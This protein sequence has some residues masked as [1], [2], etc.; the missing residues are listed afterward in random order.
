MRGPAAIGLTCL[1]A[2]R[3]G[4][5]TAN[6]D[7][8]VAFPD[9]EGKD[10]SFPA[11]SGDDSAPENGDTADGGSVDESSASDASDGADGGSGDDGSTGDD[12]GDAGGCSS[13]VAVCDP[14]H[15]SGCNAVQQCDVDPL[16]AD[17][18]TGQCL[19]DFGG[20]DGGSCS[21]SFIWASCPPHS[22]CVGTSCRQLCSCNAD[23]PT[24]QCCSDTSGPPGFML[25]RPCP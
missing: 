25:C 6:A 9:A 2:C 11:V 17:A 15:N 20:I 24:G 5:P 12:A 21:T 7:E 23:C 3:F 10:A 13:P 1:V 22:T 4:G 8:Y 14:I 19:L 18:A 16:H